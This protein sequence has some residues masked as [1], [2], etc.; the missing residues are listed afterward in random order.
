ML[1]LLLFIIYINDLPEVVQSN[2]AI[3]ADDIKLYRSRLT[4]VSREAKKK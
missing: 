1:G 4:I 2:I 3:F